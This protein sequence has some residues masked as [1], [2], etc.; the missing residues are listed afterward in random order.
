MK[1]SERSIPFIN[2][3]MFDILKV[4]LTQ[5]PSLS[6]KTLLSILDVDV[7]N[8]DH[9]LRRYLTKMVT[10]GFLEVAAMPHQ[11]YMLKNISSIKKVIEL[12]ESVDNYGLIQFENTALNR[13]DQFIKNCSTLEN[14]P[15]TITA[16]EKARQNASIKY[17]HEKLSDNDFRVRHDRWIYS[18]KPDLMAMYL[19]W[20]EIIDILN[21][22]LTSTAITLY[23]GEVKRENRKQYYISKISYW[24][25]NELRHHKNGLRL[26]D[27]EHMV[28][29]GLVDGLDSELSYDVFSN[30]LKW[31]LKDCVVDRRKDGRNTIYQVTD[32]YVSSMIIEKIAEVDFFGLDVRE[33]SLVRMLTDIID[34]Q[35]GRVITPEVTRKLAIR[36][37]MLARMDDRF[38]VEHYDKVVDRNDRRRHIVVPKPHMVKIIDA[39]SE[40]TKI[41]NQLKTKFV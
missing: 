5:G 22:I 31:L 26:V 3:A 11:V 27:I 6:V 24:V 2:K 34:L 21:S 29:R 37:E 25:L 33:H 40:V 7:A 38:T 16:A 17:K 30:S 13:V 20:N 36:R 28:R 39:W 9:H 32:T 4:F 1:V 41:V 8:P 35:R 14:K 19:V 23:T 18:V 10:F 15:V 12:I